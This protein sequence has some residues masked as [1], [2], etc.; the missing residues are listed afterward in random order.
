ML[1]VDDIIALLKLSEINVQRRTCRLRVWRFEASWPL[2]PYNVQKIS[3]SVTTTSLA[4]SQ[5]KPRAR[6]PRRIVGKRGH[7]G[8]P[9]GV[10]PSSGAATIASGWISGLPCALGG[11]EVLRPRTGALR[12]GRLRQTRPTL[13]L[14]PRKRGPARPDAWWERGGPP[15]ALPGCARPRAQQRQPVV[16]SRNC[17]AR[18]A[19]RRLLRPRTGALRPGRLRQTRI[20]PNLSKTLAFA[21]VVTEH[22][23]PIALA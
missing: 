13:A 11:P 10:R 23:H 15:V 16:G 9:S 4:S 3:A 17:P 2:Q 5:R 19:G 14:S 22:V 1:Q 12:P 7:P 6:A 18:R 8:R 21:I 20:H